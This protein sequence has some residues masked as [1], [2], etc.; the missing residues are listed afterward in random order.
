MANESLLKLHA[1][2]DVIS[3]NGVRLSGIMFMPIQILAVLANTTRSEIPPAL[4]A[5]RRTAPQPVKYILTLHAK[6]NEIYRALFHKTI[7]DKVARIRT[8][9]S[10]RP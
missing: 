7:H 1:G 10:N 4:L 3:R 8:A 2:R 9:L 6:A 5:V